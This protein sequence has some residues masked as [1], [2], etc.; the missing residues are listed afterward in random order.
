MSKGDLILNSKFD[1]NS[2]KL[3]SISPSKADALEWSI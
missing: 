2:K 3:G 1:S